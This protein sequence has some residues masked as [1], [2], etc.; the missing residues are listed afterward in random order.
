MVSVSQIRELLRRYLSGEMDLQ[1]YAESFEDQYSEL[2]IGPASEALSLA[3]RVQG[4][5]GRCSAGYCD[6]AELKRSLASLSFDEPLAAN[7]METVN[8]WWRDIVIPSSAEKPSQAP[9]VDTE[10]GA[11][12]A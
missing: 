8:S 2:N 3:D 6:E 9:I 1:G 7:K 12:F 10:R 4:L 11:V 5:L